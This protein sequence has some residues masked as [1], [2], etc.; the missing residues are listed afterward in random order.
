MQK[1]ICNENVLIILLPQ[2]YWS[3]KI[4]IVLQSF[5]SKSR[6][7]MHSECFQSTT[8]PQQNLL[9][10]H[11]FHLEYRIDSSLPSHPSVSLQTSS[12]LSLYSF[13]AF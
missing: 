11:K 10:N 13:A 1:R 9:K 7:S 6:F 8:H 12:L 5:H 4:K 2:I 3:K